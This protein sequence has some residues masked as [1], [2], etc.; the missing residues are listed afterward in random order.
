M[1]KYNQKV[2]KTAAGKVEIKNHETVGHMKCQT[3]IVWQCTMC[4]C[5][6]LGAL[7]ALAAASPL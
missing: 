3:P 4:F 1:L 6:L 5:L 7:L 2:M